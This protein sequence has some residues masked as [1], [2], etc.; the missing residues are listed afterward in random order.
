MTSMSSSTTSLTDKVQN[1]LDKIQLDIDTSSEYFHPKP[2]TTYVI[3][4]DIDKHEIDIRISDRFKDGQGRPLKQYVYIVKHVNN[5]VEQK[6][7]VSSKNL[8]RQL[9]AE[10]RKG[11]KVMKIQRIG[12]DKSTKYIVEGVQ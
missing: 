5:G 2:G 11:Y 8:V 4:I 10:I 9:D 7:S 1:Q 6:W 3:E 12:E